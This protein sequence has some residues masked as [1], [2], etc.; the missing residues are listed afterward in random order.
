MY[1][2]LIAFTGARRVAQICTN[3]AR[4]VGVTSRKL[5][6]DPGVGYFIKRDL[7]KQTVGSVVHKLVVLGL[8]GTSATAGYFI[9]DASTELYE[10][11][12]NAR[13]AATEAS[14]D[15]SPE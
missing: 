14:P 11:R 13:L 1:D 9:F 12:K 2:F 6:T 3:P 7:K 10:R 15:D 4:S 8:F 5:S